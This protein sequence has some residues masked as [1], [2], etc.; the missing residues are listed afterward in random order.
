MGKTIHSTTILH[1]N[2]KGSLGSREFGGRELRRKQREKNAIK[3]KTI[4][5]YHFIIRLII[6]KIQY[7]KIRLNCEKTW[8]K[9]QLSI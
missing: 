8:N 9:I 6:N 1:T 3:R 7:R 2:P 4:N 5:L